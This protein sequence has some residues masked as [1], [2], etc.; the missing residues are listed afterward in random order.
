MARQ[1]QHLTRRERLTLAS[2]AVRGV[3][4]GT[5]RAAPDWFLDWLTD[6]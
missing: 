4:A 5:A 2:V 1:H 3:L 6:D